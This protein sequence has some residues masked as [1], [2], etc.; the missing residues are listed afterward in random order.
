[1]L[2]FMLAFN[3]Y[4]LIYAMMWKWKV[5]KVSGRNEK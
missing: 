4:E 3:W 5:K 1:M 2:A